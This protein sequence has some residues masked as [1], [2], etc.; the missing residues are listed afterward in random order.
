MSKRSLT[1]PHP[2]YGL[3]YF[4][5]NR[6]NFTPKGYTYFRLSENPKIRSKTIVHEWQSWINHL[7]KSGDVAVRDAVSSV[8]AISLDLITRWKEERANDDPL[9]PPD[10]VSDDNDELESSFCD[11]FYDVERPSSVMSAKRVKSI[12]SHSSSSRHLS[13]S[14][15]SSTLSPEAVSLM[16]DNF[17]L[18][19]DEFKGNAWMTPAGTNNGFDTSTITKEDQ[20]YIQNTIN[21]SNSIFDQFELQ[22]TKVQELERYE[23]HPDTLSDLLGDGWKILSSCEREG[24]TAQELEELHKT[25]QR[26]LCLLLSVYQLH[27]DISRGKSE[28]WHKYYIWGFLGLFFSVGGTLLYEPGEVSS[29]ASATRKNHGCVLNGKNKV[30]GRKADGIILCRNTKL[31]ICTF[32]FGCIDNELTGTKELTDLRKLAKSMND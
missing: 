6:I 18:A 17:K 31:E 19:F 32:E 1:D 27:T 7:A 11:E 4:L 23:V 21:S 30:Q 25:F 3:D 10:N 22:D 28:S 20:V 14:R 15:S 29:T 5:N 12:S 2:G 13:S 16:K 8:A 26:T 24:M 9:S